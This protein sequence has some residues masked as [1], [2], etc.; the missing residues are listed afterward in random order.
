[1]ATLSAAMVALLTANWAG[2]GAP[3]TFA[4]LIDFRKDL[5]DMEEQVVVRLPIH[6]DVDP[7]NDNLSNFKYIIQL[8]VKTN[9]SEDR[10]KI[11]TDETIRIINNYAITGITRQFAKRGENTSDRRRKVYSYDVWANLEEHASTAGTAYASPGAGDVAFPA[12]V[13]VAGTL[14]VTGDTTLG[15]DLTIE[16]NIISANP[17]NIKPSGD[18]DDY[19][20]IDTIGNHPVITVIG[21]GL[22]QIRGDAGFRFQPSGDLSDYI[23]FSTTGNI[24]KIAAK[25]ASDL[26]LATDTQTIGV[27]QIADLLMFGSANAAWVPCSFFSGIDRTHF[28]FAGSGQAYNVGAD[29]LQLTYSLPLPTTRGGLKLYVSGT[30]I[31]LFDADGANY[32]TSRF[33]LGIEHNASNVIDA[34]GGNLATI[35]AHQDTFTAI[36][37]SGYKEVRMN[38]IGVNP[39]AGNLDVMHCLMRCYYAA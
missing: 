18:I 16:D 35:A 24:P 26:Q 14:G 33:V 38:V 4:A 12:D 17:I 13:T 28:E 11:L 36:D 8:R 21:G 5:A 23:E 37:C 15:A 29:A 19:L 30:E 39:N 27:D 20:E 22:L 25:G 1:M 3:P 31:G 9:V 34:N 10:L 7:I 2:A 32:I 6:E